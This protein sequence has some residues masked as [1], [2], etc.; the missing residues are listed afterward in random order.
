MLGSKITPMSAVQNLFSRYYSQSLDNLGNT[1]SWSTCNSTYNSSFWSKFNCDREFPPIWQ[2]LASQGILTG[3]FGSLHSYPLPKCLDGYTFY[4]PDSFASSSECFPENLAIFQEFNLAMTRLSGRNVSQTIPK[5][6]T[7]DL[8][9]NLANL[10][11][12]LST[13]LDILQQLILEKFKPWRK[14]R[15]RI[16]QT[17]LGFD[18]FFKQLEITKPDFAT[19]F[20]NHVASSMHRYWAATFPGDYEK[21][22]DSDD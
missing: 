19:F 15:R 16:Y 13:I 12:T 2:I 5:K 10:G 1:S 11:L 9:M 8:L 17:V 14:N 21:F 18:L 20:T 3:V 7:I 22:G 6:A 4:V